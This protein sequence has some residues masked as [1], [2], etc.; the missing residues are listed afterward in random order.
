M[1]TGQVPTGSKHMTLMIFVLVVIRQGERILELHNKLAAD[2]EMGKLYQ[3]PSDTSK[4][5]ENTSNR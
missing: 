5:W 2:S 1:V 4:A 3:M